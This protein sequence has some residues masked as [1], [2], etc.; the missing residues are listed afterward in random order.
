VYKDVV[1]KLDSVTRVAGIGC[2][3]LSTE[4]ERDEARSI[5]VLHTA[6]D[7]GVTLLDT[8]DAYCF[9][10]T[11]TGHNERLIARAV[12]TW[13]GG[14]SRIIVATKGGLTRPQGAWVPDGR[15]KHLAAACEASL[16]NL[17]VDRLPLYQLHTVDPRT[18]LSTSVR[19]LD[20]LKRDG[21]IEAIGLCNVT[22]GQVEE[23]RSLTEIAAVQVEI[24]VWQDDNI[25]SGVA[26]Y[27]LAHGLRLIASRPLGG[28][29][30]RRRTA[31]DP[32]LRDLAARHGATA[33]EIALA[34]VEDLSTAIV[35]LPGPT[36]ID[37]AA[38]LQ[39]ARQ[40]KLTEDDRARLDERFPA[41]RILRVSP[42]PVR[43]RPVANTGGE[44][45]LIMGLPAAGKSTLA[46]RFVDEGYARL[47]RDEQGTSLRDLVPSLDRLI[48]S[49]ST[50]IVLDNT[51]VTRKSR[52]P[53]ILA[54]AERGL[55]ARCVWLA[56]SLEEAQVNAVSRMLSR[57][58][59]LLDADEIKQ[60][61]KQDVSAFG[62]G[63]QF[64]YQ[65]E[66]EPPDAAEGFSRVDVVPFERTRGAEYVN[67]A[68]IV[69]A[70]GILR[71]FDE[72]RAAVLRRYHADGC[73]ICALAW[74]PEV[75][76]QSATREQVETA[77]ATMQNQLGVNLEI[78]YCPH[79][80]GPPVCWC[81]KPLP[82]LGVLLIERH[83]LD[84]SKCV[85][86]ADGP[87]DPGF[88]R[89]LGFVY[90]E[91]AEFFAR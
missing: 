89:K 76:A 18:P 41:G 64:R 8:A 88:A 3:R 7:A 53:V 5:A 58:G 34:W 82:G 15:A 78:L 40:I 22:V 90:R 49:G 10:H 72:Q 31:S 67:R 43:R 85:Y 63:V 35:A 77:L 48:D 45:V 27:C 28:V 16:R 75:A 61:A 84:P 66:L 11:E 21:L 36:R 44:V 19:A 13:P 33:D 30:R 1:V 59:R 69:W 25:L 12:A 14:A 37:T 73:R 57:H 54:A 52:A 91:A 79:A 70:D 62:P 20:A 86:V 38:S 39:R 4:R 50:C 81:R 23:A 55:S 9:D 65:R 6:F 32:V 26:A 29:G 17:G 51:Y 83:K 68:L 47:N 71:P 87:Q 56:T 24:S 80:A 42:A 60:S 2:M 46:R 74:H